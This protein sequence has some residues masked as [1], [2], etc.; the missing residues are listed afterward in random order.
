MEKEFKSIGIE[1]SYTSHSKNTEVTVHRKADISFGT[2]TTFARIEGFLED[3]KKIVQCYK[4]CAKNAVFCKVYLSCAVYD[5]PD[6]IETLKSRSFICWQ[7]EGVPQDGDADG[8]YLSPDPRYTSQEHDIYIDF[9][10]SLL[11]Q[12]AAAHI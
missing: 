4:Y 5:M 12:L 6:S 9:S 8:M 3:F 7:F 11:S 10:E 2:E 1:I